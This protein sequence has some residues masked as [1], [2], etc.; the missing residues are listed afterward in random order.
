MNMT[1]LILGATGLAGPRLLADI[2][3]MGVEVETRLSG[4]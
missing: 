1:L 4:A 2:E 3:R